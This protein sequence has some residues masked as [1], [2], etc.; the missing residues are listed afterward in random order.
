MSSLTSRLEWVHAR[1]VRI[2]LD[3]TSFSVANKNICNDIVL[4]FFRLLARLCLPVRS[5]ERWLRLHLQSCRDHK[6][7]ISGSFPPDQVHKQ[8]VGRLHLPSAAVEISAKLGAASKTI[9]S[10]A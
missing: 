5:I 4:S 3:W 6:F 7:S 10:G 9:R 8:R 1:Q 2:A